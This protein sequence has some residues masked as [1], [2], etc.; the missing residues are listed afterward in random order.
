M[1]LG[2]PDLHAHHATGR[3]QV[4]TAGSTT[5]QKINPTVMAPAELGL[6]LSAEFPK[7]VT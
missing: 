3:G 1:V 7:P 5:A 2:G 6:D 4:R